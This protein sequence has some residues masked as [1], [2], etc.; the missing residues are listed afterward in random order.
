MAAADKGRYLEEY[1]TVY[2]VDPD[3]VTKKKA[4]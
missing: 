1:K 2:G 3:M 4:S